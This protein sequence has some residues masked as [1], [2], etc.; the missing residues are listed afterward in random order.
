MKKNLCLVRVKVHPLIRVYIRLCPGGLSL[1][2][3]GG[4]NYFYKT[5]GKYTAVLNQIGGSKTRGFELVVF[6][7]NQAVGKNRVA[8]AVQEFTRG[9]VSELVAR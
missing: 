6:D 3:G 2:V 8:C 4:V 7:T 1:P 5:D 9:F